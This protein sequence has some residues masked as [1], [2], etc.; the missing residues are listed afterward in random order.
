MLLKYITT[1]RICWENQTLHAS[2][3]PAGW[4]P[5]Q[6]KRM[7]VS[8]GKGGES[9]M[10]LPGGKAGKSSATASSYDALCSHPKQTPC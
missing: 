6:G 5:S 1:G 9:V 2:L 8:W 7:L 4:L 10:F 3:S